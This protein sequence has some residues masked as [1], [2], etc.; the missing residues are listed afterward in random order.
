MFLI[1]IPEIQN[2]KTIDDPSTPL[3]DE[4]LIYSFTNP[5]SFTND[6][7]NTYDLPI[8]WVQFY[9]SVDASGIDG[10]IDFYL[11]TPSGKIIQHPNSARYVES[12]GGR[13]D[14]Y[15]HYREPQIAE[16]GVVSLHITAENNRTV[17]I[18]PPAGEDNILIG[19]EIETPV[20]NVERIWNLR[21]YHRNQDGSVVEYDI[22]PYIDVTS[23]QLTLPGRPSRTAW[24]LTFI[25]RGAPFNIDFYDQ[26]VFSRY[27][28]SNTG[29]GGTSRDYDPD[30]PPYYE[31]TRDGVPAPLQRGPQF[32]GYVVGIERTNIGIPAAEPEMIQLGG[33]TLQNEKWRIT[34]TSPIFALQ[35]IRFGHSTRA[36]DPLYRFA[37]TQTTKE[38]LTQ[39]L[40]IAGDELDA[41]GGIDNYPDPTEYFS[42]VGPV[43]PLRDNIDFIEENNFELTSGPFDQVFDGAT[44]Y[45]A[46]METAQY[47]QMEIYIDA[48]GRI[49]A[50]D[51]VLGPRKIYALIYDGIPYYRI[52][53]VSDTPDHPARFYEYLP[54]RDMNLAFSAE[55][56]VQK[57]AVVYSNGRKVLST[58]GD[59]SETENL[60][61]ASQWFRPG[62]VMD[63]QIESDPAL[64]GFDVT[65][66]RQQISYVVADAG[67][68]EIAWEFSLESQ[69]AYDDVLYFSAHNA[70]GVQVDLLTLP[71]DGGEILE[72]LIVSISPV[73]AGTESE[74]VGVLLQAGGSWSLRVRGETGGTYDIGAI[75]IT[76]NMPESIQTHYDTEQDPRLAVGMVPQ[77][78]VVATD[79]LTSQKAQSLTNIEFAKRKRVDVRGTVTVPYAPYLLPG[80]K[81]GLAQMAHVRSPNPL[82]PEKIAG[83][84]SS[85]LFEVPIQEV[86]IIWEPYDNMAA[87]F[88]VT[89]EHIQSSASDT[90]VITHD[91]TA[92]PAV[93]AYDD[94][95]NEIFPT[96]ISYPTTNTIRIEFAS[97]QSGTA[98]IRDLQTRIQDPV[99]AEL[100]IGADPYDPPSLPRN[101][102]P[103]SGKKDNSKSRAAV[104][105]HYDPVRYYAVGYDPVISSGGMIVNVIATF[106]GNGD[107]IEPGQ[108][109]D[110]PMPFGGLVVAWTATAVSGS[111]TFNVRRASVNNFPTMSNMSS[112]QVISATSEAVNE[113]A[114]GWADYDFAAGD[115]VR[116][117]IV[118]TPT[119]ERASIALFVRRA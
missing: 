14:V 56:A 52:A 105:D 13:Y 84:P 49:R 68:K 35:N 48:A 85:D 108:I 91:I 83:S 86:R 11:K 17:D 116:V 28:S 117:S 109:V 102:R 57:I 54:M 107:T 33:P 69:E 46:I 73:V 61:F 27:E 94:E 42:G 95:E 16:E 59:Y 110:I 30:A 88:N 9:F 18:Y 6:I 22:A 74:N 34:I 87:Q 29:R 39:L 89:E 38:R 115:I 53:S 81:I 70:D 37:E 32:S 100:T 19:Y 103:P 24:E 78:S 2:L 119:A 55:N 4:T 92:Q 40:D 118:G 114:E 12:D 113:K 106:D 93:T 47:G 8:K 111:I 20:T 23:L 26:I 104:Q 60:S 41:A 98:T 21:S 58:M 67:A 7:G 71:I 43:R 5:M 10:I 51:A 63:D 31:Q 101:A 72:T 75:S 80:Y 96:Q 66:T 62:A 50:H 76:V 77:D 97:P 3:L 64:P 99:W 112:G 82:T 90:W 79:V 45:D 44:L 15:L 25:T 1:E 65:T 36:G